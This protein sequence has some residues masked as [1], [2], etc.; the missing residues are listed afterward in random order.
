MWDILSA[1]SAYPVACDMETVHGAGVRWKHYRADQKWARPRIDDLRRAMRE[2]H[3]DA[4]GRNRKGMRAFATVVERL[5]PAVAGAGMRD[6]ILD[7][8]KGI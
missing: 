2:A 1:E 6:A 4:E 8:V 5:S 7:L 3:E